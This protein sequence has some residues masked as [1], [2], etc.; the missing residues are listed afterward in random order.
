MQPL[1]ALKELLNKNPSLELWI[2]IEES[3]TVEKRKGRKF[4]EEKCLDQG[5]SVRYLNKNGKAGLSYTT[6][7]DISEIKKACT[8]AQIL[9]EF[10]VSSVF[11]PRSSEYPF[12]SLKDTLS[13]T[14]K[15]IS[16]K[17]EELEKRAFNFAS[18]ISE[19]EKIKI[20]YGKIKCELLRK[21]LNLKWERP[22]CNFFISVVAKNGNKEGISYEWYEGLEFEF[23]EITKRVNFC[24]QKALAL[25]KTKKGKNMKI[26]VLLPPFVAVEFL[27]ILEFSFL[28]DEILKGRSYLKDKIEK[29]IFSEKIT[30]IDDGLNPFLPEGRPFDDEGQPQNRKVL[31]EKGIVKEFLFDTYWKEKAEKMGFSEIKTGNSRRPNFFSFPKISSTNFYIEKGY[32]EREKLLNL[33][34]EVFEVLE[35]LGMHTANPISGDFSLGISGIYYKDGEPMDYFCE[36]ALSGNLF[37][38][39]KN[40]VEIGSDL[41]FYGSIGSPSLL[42]EKMDL[43]G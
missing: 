38:V 21:D 40:V 16:E 10:G 26:S 32:F 2:E 24:C 9:S 34:N 4:L 25:S 42:I 23:E 19:I 8:K 7:L 22:F 18:T 30:L 37:E 28:G 31:I 14:F 3:L 39:F 5:V 12:F 35:V 6:L 33:E 15:N 13:L 43:G 17:L 29:K 36:M 27:E 41:T 20:S 11:P 1:D